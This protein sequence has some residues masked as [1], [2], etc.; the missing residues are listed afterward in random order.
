MLR[1]HRFVIGII[2]IIS[3]T[4][5][6]L[7]GDD[8]LHIADVTAD[9]QRY[10]GQ[11]IT[12]A[13]AYINKTGGT[14]LSILAA[15]VSTLDN[16]LDAQP[17]GDAVWV[18][19]FSEELKLGL[20]RPGDAVYGFVKLTGRLE[21]GEY[22]EGGAYKHRIA[23][24]QAEIIE[25][26]NRIE[27]RIDNQPLVAGKVSLHELY[28]N[29]AAY[30]GQTVTTEGYYFWN[31]VIYVLAEGIAVQ[32]DGSSPQPIGKIIWME[33]FPPDKSADLTVGPNNSYVWGKVEVTGQFQSGG[34]FG[35]DGAYNAIFQV[36]SANP[37]K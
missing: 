15:G 3:M 12:V 16:G 35:R 8:T 26:I 11:D 22:G 9:I 34:G 6:G 36:T 10:V 37:I 1:I 13:G 31:S 14:T 30:N 17:L 4:G 20:H 21:A 2:M 24:T 23:V 7:F 25:Q 32:E 27:Y 18:D 5:C 33:G 19:N 29:G 28:D